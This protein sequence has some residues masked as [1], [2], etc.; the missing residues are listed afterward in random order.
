[1]SLFKGALFFDMIC[2]IISY[3]AKSKFAINLG[4]DKHSCSYTRL[5]MY[6]ECFDC[7]RPMP[8]AMLFIF[9]FWVFDE[10]FIFKNLF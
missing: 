6:F 9:M 1:M 8:V 5:F 10:S 4:G 2:G 3:L 7:W